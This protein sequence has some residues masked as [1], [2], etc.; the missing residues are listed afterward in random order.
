MFAGI[1]VP[2]GRHRGAVERVCTATLKGPARTDPELRRSL[3]QHAAE[4]WLSGR[5]EIEIPKH[6][7]SYVEKVALASYKVTDE[8]VG[9]LCETAKLSEDEVLEVTLASAL[10]CALA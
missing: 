8:D 2:E 3:A 10:G 1:Q 9:A 6:L 4:L 5:S 7:A